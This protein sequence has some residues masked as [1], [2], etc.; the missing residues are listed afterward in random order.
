MAWYKIVFDG[1]D[2]F[3]RVE[4]VKISCS[5]DNNLYPGVG[6][7]PSWKPYLK[8]STVEKIFDGGDAFSMFNSPENQLFI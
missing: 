4:L 1:G 2:V 3:P 8:N 5:F 7:A 6:G